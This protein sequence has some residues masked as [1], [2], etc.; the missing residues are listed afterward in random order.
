MILK[1]AEIKNVASDFDKGIIK[2][3]F[4]KSRIGKWVK[5]YKNQ[6]GGS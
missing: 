5:K 3:Y 6:A 2:K 4:M 1:H